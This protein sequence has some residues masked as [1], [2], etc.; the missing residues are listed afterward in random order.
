M[1]IPAQSCSACK[2][3]SVKALLPDVRVAIF[4]RLQAANLIPN[5]ELKTVHAKASKLR[6]QGSY[7]IT[8]NIRCIFFTFFPVEKFTF[9]LN[10]WNYSPVCKL[11]T[12]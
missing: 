4:T 2:V 3:S 5:S 12:G 10:S 8:S 7:R 1:N 6:R 9:L 11:P